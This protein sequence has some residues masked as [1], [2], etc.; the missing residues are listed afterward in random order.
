MPADQH[1]DRPLAGG[2][3]NAGAVVRRGDLVLRPAGPHTPAVHE[4]LARLRAAGF[5]GVP[6]PHG[7]GDDGREHLGFLP[8]EVAV[9]PYPAWVRSDAVLASITRLVR[10]LHDTAAT[11]GV[12]DGAWNDEL[13]DPAGGPIV[14]HDDVCIENVVFRDGEAVGLIDFDFAAPGH[15]LHDLAHFAR[16]CVP[17]DDEITATHRGWTVADVPGRFR[18]L[19]DVYGLDRAGRVR[20]LEYVDDS[21]DQ[22]TAFVRRRVDAGDAAFVAQ[23][24]R[25]GGPR[26]FER[27]D[28]WWAHTRPAL[29][30]AAT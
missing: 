22:A 9:P 16:M 14:C 26:R 24:R 29:A 6:R 21:I 18:L 2:I 7:I 30:R 8:G 28:R 11:V 20:L 5:D 15:P 10:R 19:C 1:E 13:A 23:L 4:F 12:P 27:R 17:L 3:A 25:L